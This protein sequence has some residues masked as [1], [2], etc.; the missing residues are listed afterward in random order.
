MTAAPATGRRAFARRLSA[1]VVDQILSSASNFLALLLAARALTPE[2]L[3]AYSLA[4]ATYTLALGATRALCSEA[5]LVRIGADEAEQDERSSRGVFDALVLGVLVAPL[6]VVVALLVSGDTGRCLL[7]LAA[8]LPVLLAQDT[9]RYATFARG[10]AAAALLSDGVWLTLLV[11]GFVACRALGFDGAVALFA[12]FTGAGVIAGVVL[13]LR[14]RFRWHG[15][16]RLTWVR[17]NRDLGGRYFVDWAAGVGVG[18]LAYYAV[19]AVVGVAA[20]G[21]LRGAQTLYGAVNVLVAGSYIVLIPE[22]KRAAQRSVRSLHRFCLGAAGALGLVSA[23]Q[24]LVLWVLTPAQGRM[25]LGDTWE[26]ARSIILPTGLAAIA[27]GMFAGANTGI[28][29]L[30][31]AR[32]ILRARAYVVPVAL[33]G[34]LIGAWRWGLHGAAWGITVAV[35]WGLLWWWT[36][37]VRAVR[38]A[39]ETAG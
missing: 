15:D 24:L 16:R 25:L 21:S 3:G 13:A 33:F 4:M 9:M 8:A 29:A 31:A 1:G 34:P 32:E 18:Q 19:A 2:R 7:V 22:A 23:L 10:R 26:G 6:L 14:G 20:V 12:V 38:R 35:W 17:E 27:G 5:L 30:E 39:S 36:A 11:A 37:Y 28:R